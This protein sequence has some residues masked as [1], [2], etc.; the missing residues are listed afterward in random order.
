MSDDELKTYLGI[1]VL[2]FGLL[3]SSMA[4]FGDTVKISETGKKMIT[5][6]G[7]GA[8][9]LLLVSLVIGAWHEVLEDRVVKARNAEI[10]NRLNSLEKTLLAV[11]SGRPIPPESM[12]STRTMSEA[13]RKKIGDGPRISAASAPPSPGG[14]LPNALA[15]QLDEIREL[16][17]DVNEFRG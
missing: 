13:S 14:I 15:S 16:L 9:I 11:V 1:A 6:V 8:L 17:K 4:V 3:F 2:V 7:V 5:R 12:M 10:A